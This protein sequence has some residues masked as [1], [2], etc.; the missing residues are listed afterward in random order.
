MSQGAL[1]NDPQPKA[2]LPLKPA[3]GARLPD[4]PTTKQ[5]EFPPR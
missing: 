1:L 5:S 4:T 3:T 2:R